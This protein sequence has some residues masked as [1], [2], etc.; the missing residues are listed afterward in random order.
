MFTIIDSEKCFSGSVPPYYLIKG[1]FD[2]C[3]PYFRVKREDVTT[4]E[5]PAIKKRKRNKQ[6]T[7]STQS[8]TDLETQKRHELL[9]P[10]LLL[11]IEQL[12]ENW[13]SRWIETT[14]PNQNLSIP[15]DPIDFPSIQHM[16]ETAQNKFSEADEDEEPILFKL[17]SHVTKELDIFSIFNLVCINES[18][19]TR[20]LHITPE[21]T[22][23]IPPNSAFLMGSIN[24]SLN[25]LGSYGKSQEIQPCLC[26]LLI[27][28][29][30]T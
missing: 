29:I 2:V 21:A 5:G 12:T 3:Q 23:L 7:E 8:V 13:P 19:E 18:L 22:Y 4:K 9:R 6:K 26:R 28:I 14:V 16:V 27:H 17:D 24:N 25:Q 10:T 30:Y 20:L 15:S 1:E 11:C